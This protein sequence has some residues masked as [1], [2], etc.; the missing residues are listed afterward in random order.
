M[1][2]SIRLVDCVYGRPAVGISVDLTREHEG[3][4]VV[5]W[6]DQTD[7]EGRISSL[8]E[9]AQGRGSYTLVFDLDDYFR[10]LGYSALNSAVSI[11]F[12]VVSEAQHYGLSLLI[13]PASC[14][15]YRED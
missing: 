4:Q 8:P 13:T 1:S 14:V 7:D 6:H 5:R 10:K 3:S 9:S 11:R 15:A 12:H 2:V